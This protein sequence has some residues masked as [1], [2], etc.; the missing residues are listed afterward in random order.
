MDEVIFEEFKGTGNAEIVLDRE[1][2]H[3]RVWPAINLRK[4]RTR[5]EDL[6]LGSSAEK[7]NRLFPG[8]QQSVAPWRLCRRLPVTCELFQ[9]MMRFSPLW[10]VDY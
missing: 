6:L 10:C 2:A 5:N 8:T 9:P 1:M 3:R 4:S 7:H